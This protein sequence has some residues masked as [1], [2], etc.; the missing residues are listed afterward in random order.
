VVVDGGAGAVGC[1]AGGCGG[2]GWR[3]GC[4]WLRCGRLW[5]WSWM[6]AGGGADARC[7]ATDQCD[8]RRVHAHARTHG[9]TARARCPRPTCTHYTRQSSTRWWWWLYGCWPPVT[10]RAPCLQGSEST[11]F[12]A[13]STRPVPRAPA[14]LRLSATPFCRDL[15]ENVFLAPRNFF[16][17]V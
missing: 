6:A 12:S 16:K 7:V 17:R 3:R 14:S 11:E 9:L 2:R 13:T 5:W 4:R 15:Y 8:C 1:A 10:T